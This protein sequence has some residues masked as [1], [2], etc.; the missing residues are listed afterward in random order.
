M[1]PHDW[2]WGVSGPLAGPGLL[3]LALFVMFRLKGERS[4]WRRGK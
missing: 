2:D 4:G 3:T 1:A